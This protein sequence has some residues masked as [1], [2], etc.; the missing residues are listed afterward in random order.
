MTPTT[1]ATQY[2][3]TETTTTTTIAAKAKR[4]GSVVGWLGGRKR[5]SGVRRGPDPDRQTGKLRHRKCRHQTVLPMLKVE[6]SI[7]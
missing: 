5:G 2:D 6:R 4:V 3:A 1:K 7:Q